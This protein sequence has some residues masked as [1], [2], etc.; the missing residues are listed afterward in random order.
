MAVRFDADSEDY[1]R[2]VNLGAQSQWSMSCW[3]KISG[4]RDTYST[5]WCLDGG[6]TTDYAFLQTINDGTTLT[7]SQ[8]SSGSNTGFLATRALT[9]GVWYYIAVSVNGASGTMV[10]KALG[11]ALFT[12][13]TWTAGKA[14]TTHTNLRIGESVFEAEWLNGAVCAVK[15]WGAALSQAELQ[16]EAG[17]FAPVRTTNLRAYYRFSGPS[18]VD[19]S[20]N[21]NTLSGGTGT[22]A[23]PDPVIAPPVLRAN[24]FDGGTAGAAITAANSGG[25]SGDAFN[26]IA[27][28]P[29][30]S[31]A[32][33][34]RGLVATNSVAGSDTHIDWTNVTQPGNTICS[35]MYLYRAGTQTDTKGLFAL[36]GPSGV[37]S[38]VWMFAN[39][40]ISIYSAAA[41]TNVA[42][43]SVP[44][45]VGQWVR[46][47]WRYTID[48]SG[49]GTVEMWIY[50]SAD[51]TAHSDYVISST[52]AWPGGKPRDAE[53]HIGRDAG[54]QWY[55]DEIA[56]SDTKLGPVVPRLVAQV[57]MAAETDAAQ[58]VTGRKVGRV[59]QVASSGAALP[60][61][62]AKVRQVG[63]VVET[64]SPSPV[65]GRKTRLV[66]QVAE[67][68]V[69]AQVRAARRRIIGQAVE[70]D[71]ATVV[72]SDVGGVVAPAFETDIAAPIR[73]V[74]ALHVGPALDASTTAAIRPARARTIGQAGESGLVQAIGRRKIRIVGQ[75]TE[76]DQARPVRQLGREVTGVDGP[77]RTWSAT[78]TRHWAADPPRR[79]WSASRT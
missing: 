54:S 65:A 15:W 18:T 42:N 76:G 12:Y 24:T 28:S 14:S 64:G 78:L 7:F 73:P 21:S 22:T 6:S 40:S 33:A 46:I 67:S 34:H 8:A 5:A 55:V 70:T 20:G 48:A 30:Y 50:L 57:K 62:P 74:K 3:V 19:N 72:M 25:T 63:Q 69:A 29:Q 23:E 56:V 51:S 32:V 49:N 52:V 53:F 47:E 43:G 45:P 61:R 68:D 13:S 77:R 41:G 44:I 37:V 39:G 10:S 38:K 16:A 75:S 9:V 71:S 58:R 31:N 79:T 2:A 36:I 1:T 35:R 60:V 4:D 17:Q 11:D 59:A 27:G 26:N 66:V